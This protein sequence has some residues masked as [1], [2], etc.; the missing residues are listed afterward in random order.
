MP[1]GT[2]QSY[3]PEEKAGYIAPEEVRTGWP[4]KIR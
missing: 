4:L 2:I 1:K 3:D